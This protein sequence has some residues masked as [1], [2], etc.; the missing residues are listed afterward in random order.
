MFRSVLTLLALVLAPEGAPPGAVVVSEQVLAPEGV[1]STGRFG[2]SVAVHGDLAVVGAPW[3]DELGVEVGAAFVLER[4][5]GSWAPLARLDPPVPVERMGFGFAVAV[6]ESTAASVVVVGAP[7][8]TFEPRPEPG[9]VFVFERRAEGFEPVA[10]LSPSDAEPGARFGRAL[11][12]DD[13]EVLVGAPGAGGAS[14]AV[15]RFSRAGWGLVARLAPAP[16]PPA[17]EFGF[18]VAVDAD[19]LVVGA[20][21]F[22]PP[23]ARFATGAAYH[24]T[25]GAEGWTRER[26]VGVEGAAPGDRL[27][28]SVAVRGDVVLVGA[29]GAD[30]GERLDAG[31]ALALVLDG[32]DLRVDAELVADP[33]AMTG[34]FGWSVAVGR[35]LAFVGAA[36]GFAPPRE[37][38]HV[39]AF[40]RSPEGWR[41]E[42]AL[43]AG[44]VARHGELGAALSSDARWLLAGEPA[45]ATV[46]R[47]VA[48]EVARPCGDATDCFDADD[49]TDDAC[50]AGACAYRPRDPCAPADAGA[51]DAGA[52]DAATTSR[53][54]AIAGDAGPDAG[55]G[56]RGGGCGC[57]ATGR[58][59]DASLA[60]A[61]LAFVRRWGRR[62]A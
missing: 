36:G 58:P 40:A 24:F 21:S 60:C 7:F 2:H 33:R 42:D 45:V 52:L 28:A 5:G 38:A 30:D 16:P 23:G 57:A 53:D 4:R 46:G 11:A 14:G 15:F 1:S 50:E 27:G 19:T 3:I 31:R 61:A 43:H 10:T 25:R 35:D 37:P 55:P 44:G 51:A 56:R 26:R 12:L 47:A 8:E 39:F 41:L 48:W 29:P 13:G 22:E 20:P 49:C 9:S 18:A 59:A 17:A 34:L 62:R 32:S 6:H 54:A